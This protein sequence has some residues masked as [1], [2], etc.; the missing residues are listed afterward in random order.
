M[1]TQAGSKEKRKRY[2]LTMTYLTIIVCPLIAATGSC[3]TPEAIN[4]REL[5]DRISVYRMRSPSMGQIV[6]FSVVFPADYT[7][8]GVSSSVVYLL[9]G[10]GRDHLSL[11]TFDTTRQILLDAP[12]VTVMPNG[13]GGWWID[14]PTVDESKYETLVTETIAAA[15]QV[16]NVAQ[17]P[18]SRGITGWSM[19]GFGAMRYA[20]RHSDQFAGVATILGLVDFPN[21][22]LPSEQNHSVPSIFGGSR[23]MQ[24]S[25]NPL[26]HA[27]DVLSMEVMLLTAD[28]AFDFTMNENFHHRLQ[29]MDKEHEYIVFEGAH[30]FSIVE[31]SL[32]YVVEFFT[33]NLEEPSSVPQTSRYK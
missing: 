22:D 8:N 19:G 16:L 23:E 6:S 11:V 2:S 25:F 26:P 7:T 5:H 10:A 24:E 20:Q 12:F 17:N 3:Q 29:E 14:S 21:W 27:E 30:T 9:H 31:Q 13:G 33:E 1:F 15:E 18:A 32:P 28:D 4:S